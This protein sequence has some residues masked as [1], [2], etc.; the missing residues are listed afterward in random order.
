MFFQFCVVRMWC[1]RSKPGPYSSK[2]GAALLNYIPGPFKN[3]KLWGQ[4]SSTAGW[5]LPCTQPTRVQF[6]SSH[7]WPKPAK[8]NP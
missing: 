5:Y 4:S 2:A 7:M 6:P 3:L 8:S 1:Q